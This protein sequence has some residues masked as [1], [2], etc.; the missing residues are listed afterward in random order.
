MRCLLAHRH[1]C[2]G[3]PRNDSHITCIH[4][5]AKGVCVSVLCAACSGYREHF[6]TRSRAFE[7]MALKLIRSPAMQN[8][9]GTAL[10]FKQ[11]DTNARS[12]S[13]IQRLR[14]RFGSLELPI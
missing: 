6:T 7:L 14:I 10:D 13:V 4:Y 9:L 1:T 12:D 2:G 8:E 5:Q 3:N 11:Q